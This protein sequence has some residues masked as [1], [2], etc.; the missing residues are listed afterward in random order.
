[1]AVQLTFVRSAGGRFVVRSH[2]DDD[3]MELQGSHLRD[4][5]D[6]IVLASD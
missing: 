3:V 4:V 6:G 2:H 5:S 1:M